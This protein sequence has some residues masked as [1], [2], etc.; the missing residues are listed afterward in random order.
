MLKGYHKLGSCLDSPILHKSHKLL[1]SVF[2]LAVSTYHVS[3]F[4]AKCSTAFYAFL[5]VGE[6]TPT[7]SMGSTAPPPPPPFKSINLLNDLMIPG[8]LSHS[9]LILLI[10][11]HNNNSNQHP[12]SIVMHRQ[13]PF[14]PAQLLLDYSVRFGSLPGPLFANPD[15]SPVSRTFFADILCF[16]CKSCGL[17][18]MRYKSHSF[19]IGAASFAAGRGMSDAQ[20]KALRKRKT[21]D[22]LRI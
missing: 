19:R 15:N 9:N 7:S 8:I 22:F 6:I 10:F 13:S 18:P 5:Q 14:C 21:N 12:F 1:V 3:Q 2:N 16:P 20:V 4:K 11:K 17:S